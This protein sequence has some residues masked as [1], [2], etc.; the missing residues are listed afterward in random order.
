MRVYRNALPRQG[1]GDAVSA[2]PRQ[3]AVGIDGSLNSTA[4][5]QW[6]TGLAHDEGATVSAIT[7]W[8]YRTLELL[9]IIGTPV[10]PDDEA[11]T[12]ARRLLE[13]VIAT[14]PTT[15]VTIEQWIVLGSPRI[16]LTDASED[17]DLLVLGRTGTSRLKQVFLGST[18]SYC[19]RYAE[20]PVVVV[21]DSIKPER[22][23]TVAVDGSPASI[24][25]LVWALELGGE[26]EISAIY[27]HDEL[28][29]LPLPS[30]LADV[31]ASAEQML[32]DTVHTALERT[33]ASAGKVKWQ[34]A[35]GDPRKVLV[36]A[37]DPNAM[38]VLGAQGHS[39]VA[40]WVLGSL[41]D[42]AVQHAP[43]TVVICR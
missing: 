6:A 29:L 36:D 37:A 30:R 7:A 26:H 28:E 23:I 5:L 18:V 11:A 16:V 22:P 38:L 21:R 10:S 43:G 20:C 9:P 42:Y 12:T 15:D 40:R 1:P 3:I 39:R 32:D 25:A 2:T 19:V 17:H 8:D 27:S 4:S 14:T 34:V 33:G 35:Q 31:R 41:A 13:N 24:D